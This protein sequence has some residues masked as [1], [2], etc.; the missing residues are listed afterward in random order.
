MLKIGQRLAQDDEVKLLVGEIGQ[1]FFQIAMP[2]GEPP[3]DAAADVGFIFFDAPGKYRFVRQQGGQQSSI[4]AAQIQHTLSGG[5]Q[6]QD[7]LQI[8]TQGVGHRLQTAILSRASA[9]GRK[10]LWA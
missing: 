1:S 2:D 6:S 7:G 4:A 5:N 10:G 8:W 3:G 9:R